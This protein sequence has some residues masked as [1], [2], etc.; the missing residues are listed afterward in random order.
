MTREDFNDILLS[1]WSEIDREAERILGSKAQMGD[2]LF[3]A[4]LMRD[5]LRNMGFE[6]VGYHGKRGSYPHWFVVAEVE[7][8]NA[9]EAFV[10]DPLGK[11]YYP[12]CEVSGNPMDEHLDAEFEALEKVIKLGID[13]RRYGLDMGYQKE[14]AKLLRDS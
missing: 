5:G 1:L 10:I 2:C 6:A 14:C 3:V 8:D 13:V 7:V 4:R 11:S 12:E 9:D